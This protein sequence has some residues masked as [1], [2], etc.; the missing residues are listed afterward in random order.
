MLPL[1]LLIAL[2]LT[3]LFLNPIFLSEAQ[4]SSMLSDM[5]ASSS[6]PILIKGKVL[7][8]EGNLYIIKA[9]DGQITRVRVYRGTIQD[10]S[11][12]IGDAIEARVLPEWQALV[13]RQQH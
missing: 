5:P 9:E 13:L 7:E 6:E 2:V 10:E 1:N 11:I 4:S 12:K 3:L 8:I